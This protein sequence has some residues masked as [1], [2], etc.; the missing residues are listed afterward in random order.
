MDGHSACRRTIS[1]LLTQPVAAT[2]LPQDSWLGSRTS[3]RS[4]TACGSRMRLPLKRRWISDQRTASRISKAPSM[5]CF[6]SDFGPE[7]C[8]SS[9]LAQCRSRIPMRIRCNGPNVD[10]ARTSECARRAA[11]NSIMIARPPR[12]RRRSIAYLA[13]CRNTSALSPNDSKAEIAVPTSSSAR[14][15]AP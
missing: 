8:K 7:S 1:I 3:G 13:A 10:P 6:P 15:D 5:R 4:R 2:A 12:Q 9:G 11:D 14:C